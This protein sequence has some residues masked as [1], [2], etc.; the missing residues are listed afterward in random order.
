MS[1][2]CYSSSLGVCVLPEP[3]LNRGR[4]VNYPGYIHE[5]L[6]HAGL[7][8]ATILPDELAARLP[9]L[10]ILVTVGDHP[11]DDATKNV[12]RKWIENGG[13]WLSI[14]GPCGLEETL[15][16]TR[17]APTY[18]GWGTGVRSLGEGYL[19][20][21]GQHRILEF[22]DKP[23]HFF[24]GMQISATD[25]S[26]L[27]GAL[28]EHGCDDGS[29]G[30]VE[31][32]IGRGRAIFI[33]PDLTG[34]IV[35]IQQGIAVTRDGVPARD[36][37]APVDDAVLKSGDGGAL[38][39]K[40]DRDAVPGV[41]G[42][43]AFLRPVAD[44]WREI[45]LRSIFYLAEH[46]SAELAVLWMYP[47]NLPAL[48]HIS[49][50]TDN[51]EPQKA[52]ILLE[53]LRQAEIKSTW[54]VIAPGYSR[55]IIDEIRAAGHELA[56]HYDA[57]TEGLDW[58]EEEFETQYRFL[59]DLLGRLPISNKN[60]YLRWQGDMEFYAWL[61]KRGIELDQSKGPSKVG[62]AGFNFGTS[63]AYF[64]VHFDGR[65]ANVLELPTL[66][67][68]LSVFGPV[69]LGGPLLEG[70]LK[71]HGIAHFLFHPAHFDK[72]AT[73]PAMAQIV[74]EGKR[75]GLEWWTAEQINQWERAR[76]LVQWQEIRA[77]AKAM[78]IQLRSE[79]EMKQAT[80]MCLGAAGE[81]RV[82]VEGKEATTTTVRRWGNTWRAAVV[83]LP[84]K[85]DLNLEIYIAKKEA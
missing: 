15:G 17:L 57:M 56:M 64:P 46:V 80:I 70:A 26:V 9:Q 72:P 61:E 79:I 71:H 82:R 11:L 34:T 49:H 54:C 27:A 35:R 10:K 76:R 14:A 41:A 24:G 29:I 62:E 2:T 74:A 7:C 52:R 77:D 4:S 21:T 1:S 25:A 40:L 48:G 78:A 66:S 22:A 20:P 3:A 69:E 75:R 31:K 37:S 36:G 67:Q 47:R 32:G 58:A 8:Y 83:D 6:A 51:N 5:V 38:D 23:I 65:P 30:M 18:S 43:S 12:M 16:I 50:D 59:V 84:A 33:A 68:D 81:A 28:D 45:L 44:Q 73:A 39:W 19:Q 60:H 63:H 53:S 55:E 42:L 85:H 13:A